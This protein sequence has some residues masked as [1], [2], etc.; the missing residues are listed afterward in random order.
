MSALP[1]TAPGDRPG[2]LPFSFFVLKG[3][4]QELRRRAIISSSDRASAPQCLTATET[5]REHGSSVGDSV[6]S[7]VFWDSQPRVS[8]ACRAGAGGAGEGEERCGI[9]CCG[10]V[11]SHWVNQGRGASRFC[12]PGGWGVQRGRKK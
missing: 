7:S 1:G 5:Q 3:S 8:A 10:H 11:S 12:F 9:G 2:V 4:E 6:C